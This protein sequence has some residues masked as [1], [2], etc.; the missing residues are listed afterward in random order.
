MVTGTMDGKVV[1]G[2]MDHTRTMELPRQQERK[3]AEA[4][5]PKSNI[6][7][8]AGAS[9]AAESDPSDGEDSSAAQGD[10]P[11]HLPSSGITTLE[12]STAV[13]TINVSK[14]DGV[15]DTSAAVTAS[16][17]LQDIGCYQP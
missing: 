4:A 9:P 1:T 12:P 10:P 13:S 11:T 16:A 7:F 17:P 2:T 3:P 5:R 8:P 6:S 15:S 14:A